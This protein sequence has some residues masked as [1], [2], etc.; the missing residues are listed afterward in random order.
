MDFILGLPG[1]NTNTVAKNLEFIQNFQ[2][3]HISYY[4]FDASHDTPLKFLL[5]DGKM[6]LPDEDFLAGQLDL[7]D[8]FL[9]NINYKHYEISSWALLSKESMHNK[10]YWHNLNYQGFGISAG[11]HVNNFRYVNTL[12]LIHI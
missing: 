12:S 6:Y 4:L 2:P 10:L 8:N 11:G 7:I 3:S 5:N 9:K 1:E